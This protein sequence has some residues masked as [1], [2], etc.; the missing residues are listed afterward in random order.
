MKE[1]V[2]G[3]EEWANNKFKLGMQFPNLPYIVHGDFKMSEHI[4]IHNYLAEKFNPALLGT[5]PQQRAKV[6]M[7]S[8]PLKDLK[9]G[10]T[11]PCYMS[12]EKDECLA[13][14]EKHLPG[15]YACLGDN[16]FL[17]GEQPTWIDFYFYETVDFAKFL[18]PDLYTQYPALEAFHQRVRELPR[19]KQYLAN[20]MSLDN[21]RRFNGKFAKINN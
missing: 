4:P 20:H 18:N 13:A 11:M 2:Q 17:V 3:E 10:I 5:S 16:K 21:Q 12:G 14:M 15:I 6:A 8:A 7:L 9:M 19:L 1:Y